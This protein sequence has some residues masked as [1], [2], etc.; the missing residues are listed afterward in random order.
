M[1]L[2]NVKVD[3][4]VLI[5]NRDSE[6]L[7]RVVRITPK[8]F[9]VVKSGSY[10]YTFRPDGSER[11]TDAWNS[12]ICRPVTEEDRSRISLNKSRQRVK[13]E[14]DYHLSKL[15]VEQCAAILKILDGD[16]NE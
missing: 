13:N 7:G 2:E 3:Q 1:S 10:K 4:V 16:S 9:V 8:G 12:R 14:F 6:M 5:Q 11:S 15:T